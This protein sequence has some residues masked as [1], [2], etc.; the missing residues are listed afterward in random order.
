MGSITQ[1][2]ATGAGTLSLGGY[3]LVNEI[4]IS[5]NTLA[6]LYRT[7]GA[8]PFRRIFQQG[9]V[10]IAALQGGTNHY[11]IVD[12]FIEHDLEVV[13]IGD[14]A[15]FYANELFWE[16]EAGGDVQIIVWWP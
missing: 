10:G 4:D 6:D 1:A 2:S 8:A 3:Q 12:H 16:I 11:V 5:V 7:T 15:G 14:G 13:P 9:R